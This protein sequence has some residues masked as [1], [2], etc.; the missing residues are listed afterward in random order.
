MKDY[1]RF[2]NLDD[3][4]GRVYR[5]PIKATMCLTFYISGTIPD[6]AMLDTY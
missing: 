5:Y 1:T 6:F 4:V 3:Q 2:R